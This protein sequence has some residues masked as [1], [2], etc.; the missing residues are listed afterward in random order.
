MCRQQLL[1]RDIE[2]EYDAG[3]PGSR[4]GA[5]A[6]SRLCIGS[7]NNSKCLEIGFVGIPADPWCTVCLKEGDRIRSMTR[8]GGG[9]V[10]GR[11][12]QQK[13]KVILA[14]QKSF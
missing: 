8:T 13:W 6:T 11:T 12:L 2:D 14:D 7:M 10:T 4:A 9:G 1:I 3:A 5:S